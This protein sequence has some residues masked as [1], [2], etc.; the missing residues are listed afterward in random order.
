MGII[1]R[2]SMNLELDKSIDD[3]VD[4]KDKKESTSK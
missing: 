4:S 1:E 2:A 3:K